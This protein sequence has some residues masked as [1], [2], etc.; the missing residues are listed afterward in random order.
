MYFPYLKRP[1]NTKIVLISTWLNT[2]RITIKTKFCLS[3]TSNNKK[4]RN[5]NFQKKRSNIEIRKFQ[6]YQHGHW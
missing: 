1:K 2:K 6:N 5:Q 4:M 3:Q